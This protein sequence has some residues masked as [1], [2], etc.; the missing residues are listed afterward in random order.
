MT[1]PSTITRDRPIVAG[2]AALLVI[3]VQNGTCGPD[4]ASRRPEL[5]AALT[6]RVVPNIEKL[7]RGFRAGKLEVIFTVMENLTA[8]GRDRS[9]DYKL[10]NMGYA[11]GSHEARVLDA[12]APGRD[13]IVLP[14]TSSSVFNS[15]VLDYLLR[16]IGIE[17]VFVVGCLTD[18]CIDHA[19]KDG[20][21]RGYYMTCIHDACAA[22]T[23]AR[24]EAALDCFRGYCRMLCTDEVTGL[25]PAG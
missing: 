24:H 5:H 10:S 15:T 20:A 22:G 13:E 3:D 6:A 19:V 11:K 23:E 2:K 7:L 16:N 21:D 25:L 18:Q 8:D 12:I 4:E 9:L 14:K 17:D 1:H